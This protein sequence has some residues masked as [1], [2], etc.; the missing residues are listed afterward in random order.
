LSL[1]L[2]AQDI[3]IYMSTSNLVSWRNTVF[4]LNTDTYSYNNKDNIFFDSSD[5][6]NQVSSVGDC[7]QVNFSPFDPAFSSKF[8]ET[9]SLVIKSHND[10]TLF[11]DNFT[12]EFWVQ[13]SSTSKSVL[14]DNFSSQYNSW[15]IL[16]LDNQQ[17]IFKFNDDT[18]E[19]ILSTD[20][21]PLDLWVHVAIIRT[22]NQISLL[23][24]G[25]LKSSIQSTVSLACDSDIIIGKDF[26]GYISNFRIS[27][28]IEYS[29]TGFVPNIR[30]LTYTKNTV[31]LTCNS[32]TMIDASKNT[33]TIKHNS[34]I[35]TSG[36]TPFNLISPATADIKSYQFD[37]NTSLM[38]TK[39]VVLNSSDFTIEFWLYSEQYGSQVQ[40]VLSNSNYTFHLYI[41]KDNEG[42][43]GLFV[44]NKA[45]VSK[46]NP[47]TLNTWHHISIV[48][49]KNILSVYINGVL[50]INV[51]DNNSDISFNG[52]SN[53]K[54]TD[55]FIGSICDFNCKINESTYVGNYAVKKQLARVTDN[56]VI[57]TAVSNRLIDYSK[58][59]N[60]PYGKIKFSDN[61]PFGK[62]LLDNFTSVKFSGEQSIIQYDS[63]DKFELGLD[64]FTIDF[65]VNFN[66]SNSNGDI[67][68]SSKLKSKGDGHWYFRYISNNLVFGL[69]NRN[70]VISADVIILPKQWVHIAITRH[71]GEILFFVNGEK[72]V[73]LNSDL[74][75]DV[76]FTQNGLVIGGAN[77][78]SY[79]NGYMSSF[80]ITKGVALYSESFV[81][82][83]TPT[84]VNSDTVL[85]A[86]KD[87]WFYD[88]SDSGLMPSL[89]NNCTPDSNNPFWD[90][91]D[92]QIVPGSVYFDGTGDYLTMSGESLSF[93]NKS[94]TIEFWAY[95]KDLAKVNT[96]IRG[97]D[98]SNNNMGLI[99][100]QDSEGLYLGI[101]ETGKLLNI[102]IEQLYSNAWMHIA[103]VRIGNVW[104]SYLNGKRVNTNRWETTISIPNIYTIGGSSDSS[105]NSLHGYLSNLRVA[106]DEAIYLDNFKPSTYPL[107]NTD[108]TCLLLYSNNFGFTSK[109]N[110]VSV[111]GSASL[112]YIPGERNPVINFS[113][114]E[115]L[116]FAHDILS[117]F[118]IDFN[119]TLLSYKDKSI[120]VSN[121]TGP[122]IDFVL[123]F[124]TQGLMFES[125]QQ[126]ILVEQNIE[127]G[128]KY[129]IN[130]TKTGSNIRMNID[131]TELSENLITPLVLSEGSLLCIG[132][133][134]NKI[135]KPVNK[136]TGYIGDFKVTKL[137]Q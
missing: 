75:R 60:V 77:I 81:I 103:F 120:L 122:K 79:L 28:D 125:N 65:W 23:V 106:I 64:D 21:I 68:Q 121:N 128:K 38:F 115:Y 69:L 32:S 74:Y 66:N 55:K 76:Y 100:R 130:V 112:K 34:S 40:T 25:E 71:L 47:I 132:S 52:I 49:Y 17:I 43:I 78:P 80:R 114:M 3:N 11:A 36:V 82:Y 56:T 9:S 33:K 37:G 70:D 29:T 96:F 26:T 42:D 24:D 30:P 104:V 94:F 5:K 16:L 35:T 15:Q 59:T 53:N 105:I 135:G 41:H 136:F 58:E 127:V 45:H 117:D 67:C 98:I 102:P 61:T 118:S 119:A 48:K 86:C 1:F 51:T 123:S 110:N 7:K 72:Y 63:S 99:I 18:T 57:S 73:P 50:S 6:K 22:S 88:F 92:Y 62:V 85:L 134:A 46:D 12:I 20:P 129:K 133:V 10:F 126:L 84:N 83:P 2:F 89:V 93:S 14:V 108:N 27:K 131:D 111:V 101:H 137:S 109:Y 113:S 87:N 13:I 54:L 31:L 95:I 91:N 8:T 107:Q 90:T 39:E 44:G 116:Y 4:Q 19:N 124:S 97:S